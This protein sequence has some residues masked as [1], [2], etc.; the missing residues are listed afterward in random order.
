MAVVYARLDENN[1]VKEVVSKPDW[2]LHD[3]SDV[4]DEYLI[5]EGY[6]PVDYDGLKP[7]VDEFYQEAM[8]NPTDQWNVLVGDVEVYIYDTETEEFKL[9]TRNLPYLV[10]V[11]YTINEKSIDELKEELKRQVKERF[12]EAFDAGYIC[13]AL[14][15]VRIN[16]HF[17]DLQ[18]MI[19]LVRYMEETEQTE[20]EFRVYDNSFVTTSLDTLKEVVKELGAYHIQLY[21]HKWDKQKEVDDATTI[22]ELKNIEVW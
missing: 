7:T 15:N 9:E 14:D 21:Q 17:I 16:A 12:E 20:I 2:K 8:P 11:T 1:I 13:Q 10:Q 18:N 22:S 19:N 5:P 6:I 4:T 3:G